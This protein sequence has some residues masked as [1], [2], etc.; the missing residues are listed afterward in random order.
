MS[1]I[2]DKF[3]PLTDDE[4]D[5]WEVEAI[6]GERKGAFQVKWAGTDPM[7]GKGWENSWVSKGNVTD[8]VVQ[9]WRKSHPAGRLS[10]SPAMFN[11]LISLLAVPKKKDKKSSSSSSKKNSR[12]TPFSSTAKHRLDEPPDETSPKPQTKKRKS[13]LSSNYNNN[14]SV[15][16]AVR[17]DAANPQSVEILEHSKDAVHTDSGSSR[18][19]DT[20]QLV[21]FN[22]PV[23]PPASLP[24]S[25]LSAI[26]NKN[27]S[28]EL[29]SKP[30]SPPYSYPITN[31]AFVL[32]EAPKRKSIFSP[33]P[34]DIDATIVCP[35]SKEAEGEEDVL[36]LKDLPD[37]HE[38]PV[39]KI[40]VV[41][42][43]GDGMGDLN[44]DDNEHAEETQMVRLRFD[45]N[46]SDYEHNS[47]SSTPQTSL[48]FQ[49]PILSPS[50][51]PRPKEFA[52]D[53]ASLASAPPLVFQQDKCGD[54]NKSREGSFDA[55]SQVGAGDSPNLDSWLQ[56]STDLISPQSLPMKNNESFSEMGQQSSPNSH[57][58]RPLSPPPLPSPP[59]PFTA[60][61]GPALLPTSGSTP[62]NH[63]GAR[64][65]SST[66][67]D[68]R[69]IRTAVNGSPLEARI[70]LTLDSISQL[71]V[72][73]QEIDALKQQ[74]ED[75][76]EKN[77]HLQ[78]ELNVTRKSLLL[79]G[80]TESE[81]RS[82][83]KRLAEELL[84]VRATSINAEKDCEFYRGQFD[85]AFVSLYEDELQVWEERYELSVEMIEFLMKKDVAMDSVRQDAMEV[86]KLRARIAE[87]TTALSMTRGE[88]GAVDID[89]TPIG[90]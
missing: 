61:L 65:G 77:C 21:K 78:T 75:L 76:S 35:N 26:L 71:N 11:L 1:T 83:I 29:W 32:L 55:D 69:G 19:F 7:T 82:E 20:T 54:G 46:H 52:D 5:L 22:T 80:E 4:D 48:R 88:A 84:S 27:S 2:K 90:V 10:F 74:L 43:D 12:S 73:V 64:G 6:I 42:E 17:P 3:I 87:L 25:R 81:M 60:P 85:K 89:Q 51:L 86:P 70:L 79:Q 56:F 45:K 66:V 62:Q 8:D 67:K 50:A 63:L 13:I 15:S 72:H 59:Y 47:S 36:E 49:L 38:N 16:A 23:S 58:N 57:P 41:C 44:G 40:R 18:D 34:F 14:N 30:S 28:I 53:L 37:R 33:R 31:R 24:S 39:E 9:I 68:T